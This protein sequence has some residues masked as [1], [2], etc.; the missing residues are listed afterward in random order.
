MPY[1][2]DEINEKGLTHYTAKCGAISGP[3]VSM[4][5]SIDSQSHTSWTR[6]KQNIS[7]P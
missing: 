2:Y 4:F 5:N 7:L 6:Q 3:F 1:I